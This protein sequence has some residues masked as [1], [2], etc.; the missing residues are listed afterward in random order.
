MFSP[1]TLA[2]TTS[3]KFMKAM[4]WGTVA[5][6]NHEWLEAVLRNWRMIPFDDN[7]GRFR[8]LGVPWPEPVPVVHSSRRLSSS[9]GHR[10]ASASL[11]DFDSTPAAHSGSLPSQG[12]YLVCFRVSIECWRGAHC[13]CSFPYGLLMPVKT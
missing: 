1:T 8:T 10:K 11:V 13:G 12:M 5:I 3:L 4:E 7:G 6:V 2:R 9:H